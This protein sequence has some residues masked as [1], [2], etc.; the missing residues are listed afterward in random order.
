MFHYV[1]KK[2]KFPDEIQQ[3]ILYFRNYVL[4]LKKNK[5][6]SPQNKLVNNYFLALA[7]CIEFI[8]IRAVHSLSDEDQKLIINLRNAKSNKSKKENVSDLPDAITINNKRHL[9]RLYV[10]LIQKVITDDSLTIICSDEDNK[11]SI[12]LNEKMRNMLQ[13]T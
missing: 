1:L 12:T 8:D 6:F 9:D 4:R 10:T 11:Y 3:Q 2:N 7:E 13:P 5:D